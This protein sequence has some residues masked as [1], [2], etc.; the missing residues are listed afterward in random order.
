[1]GSSKEADATHKYMIQFS[2]LQAAI[3]KGPVAGTDN[4]WDF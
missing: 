1:M 2:S 4:Q 3:F